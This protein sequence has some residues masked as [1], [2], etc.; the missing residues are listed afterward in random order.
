MSYQLP[1]RGPTEPL[2]PYDQS[3]PQ[4]QT[5]PPVTGKAEQLKTTVNP[6]TRRRFLTFCGVVGA[7]GL[8]AGVRPGAVVGSSFGGGQD[9]A[10]SR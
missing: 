8:A 5:Q 2:H 6:L 9:A 1:I 3:A 4:P 10:R 7:T